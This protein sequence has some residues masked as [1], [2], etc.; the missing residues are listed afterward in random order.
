MHQ[1]R[2]FQ[3]TDRTVCPPGFQTANSIAFRIYRRGTGGFMILEGLIASIILTILVLGIVESL[4][5]A[6]QQSE[7]VR[8]AGNGVLLGRQL[9]TEINSK[10]LADPTSGSVA[11][12]ADAGMTSRSQYTRITNYNDYTD[13]SNAIPMLGG[14]TAVDVT[15]SEIFSRGVAVT[16]GAKP[17][18]DTAS[19][20]ATDFAIVTVQITAPN[21]QLIEIPEFV[22]RYSIHRQ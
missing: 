14:G 5:V 1:A 16:M 22:A 18:I 6:D 17:S 11:L 10:P 13:S 20:A 12:G 8:A 2:P 4:N 19:P 7:T 9:M 15:G 3:P 21:G